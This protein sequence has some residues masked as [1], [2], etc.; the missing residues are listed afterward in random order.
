M[1]PWWVKCII[2]TRSTI[3]EN[4]S[5]HTHWTECCWESGK[6]TCSV[7]SVPCAKRS[8]ITACHILCFLKWS[9]VPW[10]SRQNALEGGSLIP[11]VEMRIPWIEVYLVTIAF[12]H[13]VL[14]N[15]W[16]MFLNSSSLPHS[17]M[18]RQ[19]IMSIDHNYYHW[20]WSWG[21]GHIV[22]TW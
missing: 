20:I 2:S 15:F 8:S 7:L 17:N 19:R 22:D 11:N 13:I 9:L 4:W 14:F 12:C 10:N 16:S 18:L 1:L 3:T 21:G 6:C 5:E